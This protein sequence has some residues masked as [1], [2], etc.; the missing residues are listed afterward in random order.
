MQVEDKE[1]NYTLDFPP[2]VK[3]RFEL[4]NG[5]GIK[6]ILITVVAGIVSLI[7]SMLFKPIIKSSFIIILIVFIVSA[8]TL[9][10]N[11]KDKG[12]QCIF[13]TI[14]NMFKFAKGQK[15]FSYKRKENSYALIKKDI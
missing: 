2:N 9:L 12:N 5:L 7:L 10:G 3:T 1:E 4:Y 14:K 13:G 15:Y 6:E 8:G 11:M